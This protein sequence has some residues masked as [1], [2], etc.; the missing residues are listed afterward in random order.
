VD[1]VVID[2]GV[3][4]KILDIGMNL[5]IDVT[6]KEKRSVSVRYPLGSATIRSQLE[7]KGERM[8]EEEMLLYTRNSGLAMA[9]EIYLNGF[10]DG[11][12]KVIP[13]SSEEGCMASLR[14]N[15]DGELIYFL[16][17]PVNE[18]VFE[19]SK[20]AAVPFSIGIEYGVPP[21]IERPR[22]QSG[23]SGGAAVPSGAMSGGRGGGPPAGGA[24]RGGA[25]GSGQSTLSED[26]T[27]WIKGLLLASGIQ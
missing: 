18:I 9:Y 15:D 17:I 22:P 21:V 5:W 16:S 20:G 11:G 19:E 7:R 4:K 24:S 6:G 14:Y 3:Q 2:P 8:T 26:Q 13:C 27:I 10:G 25:S 23:T 12:T 1:I